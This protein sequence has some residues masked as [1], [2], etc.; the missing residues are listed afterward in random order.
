MKKIVSE[1]IQ[2]FR[3]LKRINEANFFSKA[4]TAVKN[5][6]KKIGQFFFFLSEGDEL[7]PVS[8]PINIGI[9]TKKGILPDYIS[10]VAG[11]DDISLEPGLVSENDQKLIAKYK[12]MEKDFPVDEAAVPLAHP[13]K[14]MQNVNRASLY[15]WIRIA[16]S[17]PRGTPL[18]I[19]GA[20]GIGKTQIVE[21][22]VRAKGA[23]RL[24]DVQTSKMAPDDW[25]LPY[26]MTKAAGEIFDVGLKQS[27]PDPK[28]PGRPV[29]MD[30]PKSWLPVYI[31]TGDDEKDAQLDAALG[32]GVVFLDELSRAKEEVQNTCLKLVN[33]RIIG[34]ARIGSQ[35][36]IIAASNRTID[37][38]ET[39]PQWSAALGN[40]FQNIN[41]VPKYEEWKEWA[42]GKV[43]SRL[44]DFIEFHRDMFYTL[45]DEETMDTPYASPR[46]WAAAGESIEALEK[47]AKQ[48]GYRINTSMIEEVVS[49]SVGKDVGVEVG[50]FFRL[51]DTFSKE[52]IRKVFTSPNKA[53]LPKKAGTGFDLAEGSAFLSLV[54][55]S[56]KG[57]ELPPKEM[58]NFCK[59]LVKLDNASLAT[60]ALKMLF[61]Y[62]KYMHDELGEVDGRDKYKAGIDIFIAKYKDIF[63][64]KNPE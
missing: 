14:N 9:M 1:S 37:D 58:E 63:V 5:F 17:N 18:M 51:M 61:N 20:P 60:N 4:I 47:D 22:M 57:G 25:A 36:V 11:K 44:L 38:P 29:A 2:E 15:R 13:N 24:V 3:E 64:R 19:W 62:H 48:E 7:D 16:L 23:G 45:D 50:K 46:S 53:P 10:Y 49:A 6:F 42:I 34:D 35:W 43:D 59:Y 32:K 12:A 55:S 52:D 40:R 27:L 39:L 54:I 41:Y 33:Q 30:I 28:N 21:E 31:P 26:I 56:S 8:L